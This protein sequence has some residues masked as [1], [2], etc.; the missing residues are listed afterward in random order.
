[1]ESRPKNRAGRAEQISQM[2]HVVCR[3]ASLAS[4]G[5]E[6]LI[7]AFRPLDGSPLTLGL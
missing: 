7:A 1:M 5:T 2:F 3:K 4:E 6:L